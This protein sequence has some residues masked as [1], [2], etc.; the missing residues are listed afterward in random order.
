[1]RNIVLPAEGN[2]TL[3]VV[4]EAIASA[5]DMLAV[6]DHVRL[7]VVAVRLLD[8]ALAAFGSSLEIGREGAQLDPRVLSAHDVFL[9]ESDRQCRELGSAEELTGFVHGWR[10]VVGAPVNS[11]RLQ[12]SVAVRRRP[13]DVR[14]RYPSWQFSLS[15]PDAASA[16]QPIRQGAVEAE[17]GDFFAP[18]IPEA[19]AVW[20]AQPGLREQ[21]SVGNSIPCTLWDRRAAI[22]G[23]R[24]D[25]SELVVSIETRVPGD[26]YCRVAFDGSRDN[27][28]RV[29][30]E[31]GDIRIP[32]PKEASGYEL[33]L[34]G[35]MGVTYDERSGRTPSGESKKGELR[36]RAG[37]GGTSHWDMR[38]VPHGTLQSDREDFISLSRMAELRAIES[39][40]FDLGRLIQLCEEL[41][42]CS[43]S[44]CWTAVIALTRAVLD[45]VAPIFGAGN[46][47]TVAS[48]LSGSRSTKKALIHLEESARNIADLFLHQQ[49]RSVELLATKEQVKFGQ[50]LDLLLAEIV[51][52]LRTSS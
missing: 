37:L 15:D 50:E 9:I 23:I 6:A 31:D 1:M 20:L 48:Q 10:A 22:T 13:S 3:E 17:V 26:F 5:H 8:G 39:S 2:V 43:S 21:W 49:I 30:L 28:P 33:Y 14:S 11:S 36:R 4:A 34:L 52:R 32:I 46:F 27:W 41:N 19:A 51:R 29:K 38:A 18:S 42:T 7:R 40:R 16:N 25:K 12:Q 47:Q 24:F 35:P 44:N 45:H